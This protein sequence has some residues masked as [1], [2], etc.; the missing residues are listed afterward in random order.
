MYST[1][2]VSTI[3]N[4]LLGLYTAE[5]KDDDDDDDLSLKSPRKVIE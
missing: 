5:R 2:V 1:D 3:V 4:R